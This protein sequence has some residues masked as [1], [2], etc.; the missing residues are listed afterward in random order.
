MLSR[1][2]LP[3]LPFL[4]IAEEQTAG[5]GRDAKAW[6][7][8]RGAAALTL[9]LEFGVYGIRAEQLP[10]L[11]LSTALAL[12]GTLGPR[13]PA[14]RKIELHWPNDLYV[15]GRKIAGILI[16]SPT[17][18]HVLVGVGINV[19]NAVA[20]T[21]PEFHAEFAVR[22]ITSL[23]DLSG[24]PVALPELIVDFLWR[25]QCELTKLADDAASVVREAGRRCFQ[26]GKNVRVRRGDELLSGR[27]TGLAPDG[28]LRLETADGIVDVRS[29]TVEV[30]SGE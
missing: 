5:R 16:E 26:S 17:S 15:D 23:I 9:G 21:P 27:C 1:P 4:V 8:A 11:A 7:S 22:P 2:V 12:A 6:W 20:A 29:G 30:E 19:N 10:L 28:S 25:F 3:E 14:S 24:E 13:V 18:K